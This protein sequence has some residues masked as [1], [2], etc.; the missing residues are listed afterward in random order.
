MDH[1]IKYE[2]NF[3]LALKL[4]EHHWYIFPCNPDKTP[5]VK[6]KDKATNDSAEICDW[7][8]RWPAA[9][10][11]IYCQKSGFFVVDI[12]MNDGYNGFESW[13]RLIDSNSR[14][15][16]LNQGPIQDTPSGGRHLL[17]KFPADIVIPNNA[18]QLGDGLDLR[19]NGYI[20]TGGAYQWQPDHGPELE[21]PHAPSWLLAVIVNLG[22]KGINQAKSKPK[23]INSDGIVLR[24]GVKMNKAGQIRVYMAR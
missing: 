7:W 16:R 24:F 6:W 2:D 4:A 21:L 13:A 22:H 11:G 1:E 23:S 18:G 10:I 3:D 5:K 9:L 19:S 17:F 8:A 14:G 15:A 20:C 12:D